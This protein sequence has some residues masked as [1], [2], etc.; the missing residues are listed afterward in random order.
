MLMRTEPGERRHH[1]ALSALRRAL[2]SVIDARTRSSALRSA[3]RMAVDEVFAC[4]VEAEDTDELL[5]ALVAEIGFE[6]ALQTQVAEA[7]AIAHELAAVL[8]AWRGHP[9]AAA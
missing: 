1:P 4:L 2:E 7:E 6:L 8:A 9:V 3:L 5:E